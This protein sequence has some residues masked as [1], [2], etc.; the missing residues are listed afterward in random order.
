MIQQ[1][2]SMLSIPCLVLVVEPVGEFLA[3]AG[4]PYPI[5]F[6]GAQADPT[7]G[8]PPTYMK[9]FDEEQAR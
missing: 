7:P 4:L 6:F 9:L 1:L 3:G 8:W 5:P 2:R